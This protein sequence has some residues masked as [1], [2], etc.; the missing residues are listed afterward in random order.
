MDHLGVD[1]VVL[2]G[3]S[4]GA[5]VASE[6]VLKRPERVAGVV[7]EDS[8]SFGKLGAVV[9]DVSIDRF[10][11][12]D[13]ALNEKYGLG[14][15]Y[16]LTVLLENLDETTAAKKLDKAFKRFIAEYGAPSPAV[17]MKTAG[18]KPVAARAATAKTSTTRP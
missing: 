13:R 4:Q 5:C 18:A 6:M 16:L 11:A 10:D 7:S 14:N 1:R 17:A 2:V 3:H 9:A 8:D 15:N 12:E